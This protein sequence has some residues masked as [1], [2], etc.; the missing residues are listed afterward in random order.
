MARAPTP[1]HAAR[2]R[3]VYRRAP[4]SA[5]RDSSYWRAA[6]LSACRLQSE[7]IDPVRARFSKADPRHPVFLGNCAC[8]FHGSTVSWPGTRSPWSDTPIR[9][10][11]SAVSLNSLLSG[12][13]VRTRI[14][15]GVGRVTS[16]DGLYPISVRCRFTACASDCFSAIRSMQRWTYSLRSGQRSAAKRY[17]SIESVQSPS[18]SSLEAAAIASSAFE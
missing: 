3:R 14:V 8:V 2:R 1:L 5:V 4:W 11:V 18:I 13:L 12:H 7:Q 6:L 16:N 17:K 15:G 9:A 10:I